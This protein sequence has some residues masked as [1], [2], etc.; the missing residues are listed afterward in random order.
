MFPLVSTSHVQNCFCLLRF[1]IRNRCRA[2]AS[3]PVVAVAVVYNSFLS[4]LFS[5]FPP[6][7]LSYVL[8]LLFVLSC[9]SYP[10]SLVC[11]V[12]VFSCRTAVRDHRELVFCLL[13]SNRISN[14]HEH[15]LCGCQGAT[16]MVE[17]EEHTRI[18][19]TEARQCRCMLYR[20]STLY[21]A[22][23]FYTKNKS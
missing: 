16:I 22:V 21:A 19:T 18:Y 20:R 9:F 11:D 1:W 7:L 13:R 10:A 15:W 5:F 4:Y 17:C 8:C 6:L 2:A 12:C 23:L 14:R 3:P